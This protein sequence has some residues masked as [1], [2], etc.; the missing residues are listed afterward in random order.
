MDNRIVAIEDYWPPVVRDTAEFKQI[1]TAE[2]PEFN[3]L[4]DC[5]D[6]I[7]KDAFV[8]DS[9]EY[10]VERWERMLNIYPE[11]TDT[12]NDRKTR[13]LTYLNIRLPYSW[14]VLKN[15]ITSFVG[16]NNFTMKYINDISKLIIRVNVE[17]ETQFNTILTLLNNVVPQNVIIDL[18]YLNGAE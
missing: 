10:G 2:N 9:T 4:S 7:M 15:M 18:D 5:I 6:R 8:K 14:R 17:T 3:K 13:I 16:E 12:L 1:A 11:V